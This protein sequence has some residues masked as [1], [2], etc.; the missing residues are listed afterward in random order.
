MPKTTGKKTSA[1]VSGP[2]LELP[3]GESADIDP[4][5][6]LLDPQNL[7]LLERTD[8]SIAK[9]G[10]KLIR[11]TVCATTSFRDSMGR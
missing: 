1:T 8:D 11:P 9:V 6:L 7:R 4:H 10:V 5:A 3:N 2:P